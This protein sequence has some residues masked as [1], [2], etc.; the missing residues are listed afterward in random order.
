MSSRAEAAVRARSR[1]IGP[2]QLRGGGA[3]PLGMLPIYRAYN[4]G[5]VRGVDSNHRFGTSAAVL[6]V[7]ARGW[8]DEG[9]VMCAPL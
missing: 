3:C 1:A 4:R 9:I 8:K 5:D 7:I 2:R 6:E